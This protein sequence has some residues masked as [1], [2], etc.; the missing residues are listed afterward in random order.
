MQK[1]DD[2]IDSNP[3]TVENKQECFQVFNLRKLTILKLVRESVNQ[4]SLV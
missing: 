3:K 2:E 4:W 1:K